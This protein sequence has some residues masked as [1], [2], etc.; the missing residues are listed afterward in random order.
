[1]INVVK[2]LNY[3]VM[4]NW[5]EALVE[6]RRLDHRLNVL[7]D[8]TSSK[9]GY[10]DDAFARYLSGLLYEIAGDLNNAFI[11]YRHA[12]E[13]YRAIRSWSH[14]PVPP[15]LRADLLRMSEALHL[16]QEQEK[17]RRE[18]SETIWRPYAETQPVAHVVVVTYNGRAPRK[19]DL[20]ID[21]PVS[22]DALRLVLLTK[23]PPHSNSKERRA[24]ESVL[25]GLNG[26][27]ARIAIPTL[28]P[29]KTRVRYTT[30]DVLNG[31]TPIVA[32]SE[33]MHNLTAV[34]ERTL[35]DQLAGISVKAV[36]RAVT[37]YALA[38]GMRQGAKAAV[39]SDKNAAQ[40]VGFLVGALAHA[41][42]IA[43]EEADTRSWRTLP[44]EIH[45]TRLW[46]P[47]GT[48]ELRVHSKGQNGEMV[49]QVRRRA[50]TL[51]GGE[52]MVITERVLP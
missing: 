51:R 11:A 2:A 43:S 19:E 26:H 17:Y 34:A 32:R 52:T 47:P 12:Y 9:D 23:L 50:V 37:K 46:L 30:V 5:N 18:F 41:V 44:D 10:R 14:T 42:A 16:E 33:L 24:V 25:Y 48:Y 38:D 40:V 4:E 49:G 31:S 29:Q 6:A 20:M 45:V 15:I 36:A 13:E 22:L 21:V 27:I 8:R 35:S 7:K 39:G 3:A 28:V 1:M